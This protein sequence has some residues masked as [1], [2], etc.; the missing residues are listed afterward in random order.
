M[1]LPNPNSLKDKNTFTNLKKEGCIRESLAAYFLSAPPP[2][3]QPPAQRL[4]YRRAL[5]KLA[6]VETYAVLQ[7]A[8]I[9]RPL[10]YGDLMGLLSV[11]LQAAARRLEKE[12]VLLEYQVP[13][14]AVCTAAEPRLIQMAVIYLL[15]LVHKANPGEPL[16]ASVILRP[17]SIFISVRSK[18]PLGSLMPLALVRATARLHKGGVVVS[19][20]TAAFSVRRELPSAIGL[21]AVPSMEELV[22]N[23]LSPVNIGLA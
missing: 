18:K 5:Q 21:F 2:D 11:T 22:N 14:K 20:E 19:G 16:Q 10:R 9:K 4:Q 13:D 6:E 12:G 23:P 15:R 1:N 3:C 8:C 7:S 17:R